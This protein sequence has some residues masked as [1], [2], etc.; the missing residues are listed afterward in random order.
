MSGKKYDVIK[1][2]NCNHCGPHHCRYSRYILEKMQITLVFIMRSG[3]A[4]VFL[5]QLQFPSQ[6]AEGSKTGLF[7]SVND[8][9]SVLNLKCAPQILPCKQLSQVRA[10]NSTQF[11][12]KNRLSVILAA[13]WCKTLGISWLPWVTDRNGKVKVWRYSD[14]VTQSAFTSTNEHRTFLIA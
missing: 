13:C 7:V 4:A 2:T 1:Q 10:A 8:C 12:Q 9:C 11:R 6:T 14:I 5:L 3:C